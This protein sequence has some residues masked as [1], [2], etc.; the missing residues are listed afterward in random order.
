MITLMKNSIHIGRRFPREKSAAR[1][2]RNPAVA[3]SSQD[4][5]NVT[6]DSAQHQSVLTREVL[7]LLAPKDGEII[8]DA[9]AGAG[10]H[11]EALAS[12]AKVRL[13]AFDADAAAVARVRERLA[14]FGER[15][16][17][18]EANFSDTEKILASMG[19][20]RINKALFD[21]GWNR[22]QL[23]AGRGFSFMEDEPL[24]M[25]YGTT[26][27]SG[28]TAR[29]ILNSWSE[30]AIADV[31][32]GYGE[33]RY[34]RRI[35]KVIVQTRRTHSI[36]T[37]HQ[38][39]ELIA[40]AV[41]AG[42]RHGRLHFATKTFQALRIAVNDELRSLDQGLR[43]AWNMLASHGRLA[44]IS[45]HS[46][47]DRAVKRLFLEFAREDAGRLVVKKPLTA[48]REE[49]A[50]NPSARSAKLRV[51]EKHAALTA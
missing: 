22:G 35:A 11:A 18:L 26:P 51:I 46:I 38:L 30:E 19:V 48:S 28:F 34:A 49:I 29:D 25:N 47:E 4:M 6:R 33:E 3:G 41:P 32:F 43:G 9:T 16:T 44:V 40:G 24:L 5:E 27:A 17:V 42:Y 45:F 23:Y 2:G 21:L 12:A 36:E 15:T 31:L 1:Y 14:R 13:V 37:T 7:E 50:Q 39:V 8:L 20:S 10:G